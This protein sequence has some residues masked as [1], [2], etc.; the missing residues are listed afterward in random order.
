MSIKPTFRAIAEP[1]DVADA[2]LDRL[3]QR[4]GVPTLVAGAPQQEQPPDQPK[5]QRPI[6]ILVPDYVAKAVRQLAHDEECSI[7]CVVLKALAR[8]GIDVDPSDLV[9]DARRAKF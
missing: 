1:L 2:D 3:N 9:A 6:N 4:M 7:R 5:P 8:S